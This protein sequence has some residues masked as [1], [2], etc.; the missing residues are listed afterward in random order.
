MHACSEVPSKPGAA[1][2]KR[3][4]LGG[5]FLHGQVACENPI[6]FCPDWWSATVPMCQSRP[7]G[8]KV[9]LVGSFQPVACIPEPAVL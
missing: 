4:V 5:E 7:P 8:E 2:W 9:A 3:Q 6:F 1:K